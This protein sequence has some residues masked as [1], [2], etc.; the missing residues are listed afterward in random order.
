MNGERKIIIGELLRSFTII[1]TPGILVISIMGVFIARYA[2]ELHEVSTL[3]ALDGAGLQYSTIFQ[4]SMYSLI[5]SVI[6]ILLF[7]ERFN[8]KMRFI[9]RFFLMLLAT[10]LIFCIFAVIFRWIPVDEPIAWL[11]LIL[12]TIIGFSI[13]F[14]LTILK[15][16]LDG[17][18]YDRL[19]ANYKAQHVKN[20]KQI[21]FYE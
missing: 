7:S 18:K 4:I 10:L 21:S 19:L 6:S 9:W 15:L 1:F 13:G 3:F 11:G 2:P 17:K 8:Y 20:H 14:S 12:S 5:L 16:K